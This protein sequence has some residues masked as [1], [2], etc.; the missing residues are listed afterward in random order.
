MD[1]HRNTIIAGF[2]LLAVIYIVGWEIVLKA[3]S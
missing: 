2:A 3:S 1:N